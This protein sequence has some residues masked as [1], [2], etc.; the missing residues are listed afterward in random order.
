MADS[1]PPTA[2]QLAVLRARCETGSRKG[3]AES[4]G[5]HIFTVGRILRE[6]QQRCR[7]VDDAQACWEHRVELEAMETA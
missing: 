3:A 5:I 4:L 1:R 7:C 2:R 6:M